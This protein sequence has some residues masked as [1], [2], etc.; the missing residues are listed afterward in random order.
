[1]VVTSITWE[2]AA[3]IEADQ[4]ITFTAIIE[5][6]GT[7]P[8][9]DAFDVE[10]QLNGTSLGSQNVAPI[11]YPGD[12]VTLTQTWIATAGSHTMTVIADS[13]DTVFEDTA[14]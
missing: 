7:G 2:P 12:T 11:L 4:Q 6:S 8:V 5:N 14:G 13:T 1:L 10:F 3:N 9:V